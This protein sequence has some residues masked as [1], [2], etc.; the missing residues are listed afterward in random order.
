ML[1]CRQINCERIFSNYLTDPE[2]K[3]KIIN[4]LNHEEGLIMP[5]E[6]TR[7]VMKMVLGAFLDILNDEEEYTLNKR[8]K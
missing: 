2:K 6:E 1:S 8:K 7:G 4:I 5:K 3:V